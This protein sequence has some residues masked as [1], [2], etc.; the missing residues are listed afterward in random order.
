VPVGAGEHKTYRRT[1]GN[2]S[3][4]VDPMRVMYGQRQVN[5]LLLLASRKEFN[6]SED[7]QDKGT[8]VSQ[9]EVSEGPVK[10]ITEVEVNER[11]ILAE[12]YAVRLGTQRQTSTNFSPN[13]INAGSREE[14]Q[15]GDGRAGDRGRDRG[16]NHYQFARLGPA[17]RVR[18]AGSRQRRRPA[19][20]AGRRRDRGLYRKLEGTG[21]EREKERTMAILA[22]VI[23]RDTLANRPSATS[24]NAGWLFM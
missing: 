9:G 10:S 2:E 6:P 4:L 13:V 3:R 20:R 14:L 22:D 19:R 21:P 5:A 16:P 12:N 8:F 24:N 1:E 18:G 17:G 15:T 7:N 11:D 23:P